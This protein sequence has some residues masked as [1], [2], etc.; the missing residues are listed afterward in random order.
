M[1]K[2]G[3]TAILILNLGTP[4]NPSVPAVR[5]YLFEFLND[6]RVIDIPWLLRK[7]LVNLIIV[8]FRA[9]KSAK[10]YQILWT[11]KGSPLLYHGLSLREKLQKRLGEDFLVEFAMNYQSPNVKGVLKSILKQNVDRI[12]LFPIFPQYASS[13]T[14]SIVEKMLKLLAP[15]YKIPGVVIIPQFYHNPA[16]VEAVAVQVRRHDYQHYDHVLFSYHGLPLSQVYKSHDDINCAQFNCTAEVNEY[17]LYCYH[18]GCYATTRLLA[19]KLNLSEGKYSVSF[20]SRLNNKWLEPFSDKVLEAFP[21]AGKKRVLVICPSFTA[22][23]LETIVEI[24]YDYKK[25]FTNAG[26]DE[27]TLVESLNDSDLWVDAMVNIIDENCG[28]VV[29]ANTV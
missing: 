14:G 23:C 8:P 4:D 13:S 5:K 11:D 21:K 19:K 17:N 24:G 25:L 15:E 16:Y 2:K 12:V 6:A 18:A 26:G 3:K 20:Q 29:L 28:N 10:L 27:L 22:D 7:I 1:M 9:P